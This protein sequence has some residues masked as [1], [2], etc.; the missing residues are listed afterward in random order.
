M[1]A[2]KM[3]CASAGTAASGWWA[4]LCRCERWKRRNPPTS[5]AA[6]LR[7]N[8]RERVVRFIGGAKN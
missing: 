4:T 1:F 7:A 8:T 5:K 3:N 2:V 6:T